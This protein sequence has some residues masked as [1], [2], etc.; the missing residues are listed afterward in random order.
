MYNTLI[1]KE[2]KS[3][4]DTIEQYRWYDKINK[5]FYVLNLIKMAQL[6][7]NYGAYVTH[8]RG[9]LGMIIA[10]EQMLY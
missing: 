6:N 8:Y 9:R 3:F 5:P 10:T 7:C 2:I 4:S 1:R